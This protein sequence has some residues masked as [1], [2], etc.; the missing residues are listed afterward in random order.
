MHEL[1]ETRS[2]DFC[3]VGFFNCWSDILTIKSVNETFK[4]IKNKIKS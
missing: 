3:L 2:V 1:G 4:K